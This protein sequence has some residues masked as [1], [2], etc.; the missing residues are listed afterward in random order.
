MAFMHS[1]SKKIKSR[2]RTLHV[3]SHKAEAEDAR[4]AG[5]VICKHDKRCR[6]GPFFPWVPVLHPSALA[7]LGSR[8]SLFFSHFLFPVSFK[9][10]QP[11]LN[12]EVKSILLAHEVL[13]LQYFWK[14]KACVPWLFDGKHKGWIALVKII[15]TNALKENPNNLF[16]LKHW[17]S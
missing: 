5:K 15:I 17:L 16:S 13:T 12:T 8:S 1:F 2:W 7:G 3:I 11:K 6:E 4:G 14:W 10:N 9:T